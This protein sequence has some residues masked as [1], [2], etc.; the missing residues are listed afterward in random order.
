MVDPACLAALVRDP[1]AV[2]AEYGLIGESAPPCCAPWPSMPW[3]ARA[4][5][6]AWS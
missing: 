6:P 5:R 2:L 3:L 1:E 4:R